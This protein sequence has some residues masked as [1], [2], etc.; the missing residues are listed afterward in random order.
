MA[1]TGAETAGLGVVACGIGGA[2]VGPGFASW[3][4][5]KIF[6]VFGGL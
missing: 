5:G 2:V 4:A 1:A 3:A 6:G